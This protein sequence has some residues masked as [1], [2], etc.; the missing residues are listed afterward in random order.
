MGRSRRLFVGLAA[1]CV[2]AAVAPGH[3]AS[4]DLARRVVFTIYDVGLFEAG[5]DRVMAQAEGRGIYPGSNTAARGRNRTVT[6]ALMLGQRD[7]VLG[8]AS[9]NVAARA[10]DA[11]L[12]A[13]L[14]AAAAPGAV[15]ETPLMSEAVAVVKPS[16]EA[17]LWDQLAR[18]ARGA[19]EFP[20][21]REQRTRCS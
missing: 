17:A 9:I 11:E 6:R 20:C 18:T 13:L 5:L 21:T 4:L 15:P 14:S 19:A 1:L 12:N 8:A 7:A 3:A 16:F 2:T 10:S